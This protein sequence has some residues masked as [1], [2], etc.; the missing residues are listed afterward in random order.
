M[1]KTLYEE[2]NHIFKLYVLFLFFK[3]TEIL[4]F[5]ML[6]LLSSS[7]CFDLAWYQHCSLPIYAVLSCLISPEPKLYW[8]S[9][10]ESLYHQN[11]LKKKG[12][13]KSCVSQVQRDIIVAFSCTVFSYVVSLITTFCDNLGKYK[14][15]CFPL[16]MLI[17]WSFLN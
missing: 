12:K 6:F 3:S 7:P 14:I 16:I 10:W 1:R 9:I 2:W 8:H 17:P 11:T 13:N 4:F 15:F 5:Y